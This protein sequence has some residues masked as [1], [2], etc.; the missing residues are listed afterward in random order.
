MTELFK[1]ARQEDPR[2]QPLLTAARVALE[3]N[4]TPRVLHFVVDQDGTPIEKP[5]L[6]DPQ[7]Q[8]E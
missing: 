1:M 5:G 7:I 8:Q 4:P 3:A 2:S 6:D